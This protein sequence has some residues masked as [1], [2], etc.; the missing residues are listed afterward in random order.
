MC[1]RACGC[2]LSPSSFLAVPSWVL[3]L[4][5]CT[6]QVGKGML[7]GRRCIVCMSASRLDFDVYQ[8]V[9]MSNEGGSSCRSRG[10]RLSFFLSM[11]GMRSWMRFMYS[12]AASVVCLRK[13]LLMGHLLCDADDVLQGHST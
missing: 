10:S 13:V 9:G 4:H 2:R 12:A 3:Q 7:G 5:C 8:S 11:V 1:S 6:W